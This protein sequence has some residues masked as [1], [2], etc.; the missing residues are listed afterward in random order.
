M[1]T[2]ATVGDYE[3]YDPAWVTTNPDDLDAIIAQAERDID[4]L[5]GGW[6]VESN[7]LK[8]GD[9]S[10][11]NPKN[12][13]AGQRVAL[14]NAVCAQTQYRILMGP[15]FFVTPEY[16]S[17]SGPHFSVT[18]SRP[19]IGPQVWRELRGVNLFL[20]PLMVI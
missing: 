19:K 8:F 7:G 17:V 5:F 2:Y 13:T 11:A 14:A 10:G 1:A 18:G 6:T 9:P 3:A 20:R 16:E 15:E 4:S 12:L